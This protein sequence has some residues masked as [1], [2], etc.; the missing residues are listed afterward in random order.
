MQ[1]LQLIWGMFDLHVFASAWRSA[2]NI[3]KATH[4]KTRDLSI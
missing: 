2:Q 4:L 1:I 3:I